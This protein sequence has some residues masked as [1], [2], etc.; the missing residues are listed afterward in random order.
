MTGADLRAAIL[1]LLDSHPSV[2]V[3]PAGH[4]KHAMRYVTAQGAPIGFEPR[5]VRFQNLWARADAVRKHR[6]ADIDSR[7]YA[8]ADFHVSKPNHDL[9]GEPSFKDTDLVCFKVK[10]LWQAA[11]VIAEVAGSG[12]G[13]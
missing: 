11:R 5:T 3:S 9:F 10:D 13:S 1:A 4:A 2:S 12:S 8:H 7:H 6:L